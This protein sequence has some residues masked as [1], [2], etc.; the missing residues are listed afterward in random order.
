MSITAADFE[1]PDNNLPV[2]VTVG[3]S[4]GAYEPEGSEHV[5]FYDGGRWH[6]QDDAEHFKAPVASWRELTEDEMDACPWGLRELA[7]EEEEGD[8]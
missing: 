5:A 7:E 6:Y 8:I 2:M 4:G 1:P 3:E